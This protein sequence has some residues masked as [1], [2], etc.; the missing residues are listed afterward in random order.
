[1]AAAAGGQKLF[2]SD[3]PLF[4]PSINEESGGPRGGAS[5]VPGR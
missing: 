4:S 5:G 3:R 2:R 1:M